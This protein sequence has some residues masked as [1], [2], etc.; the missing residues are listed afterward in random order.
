MTFRFFD[1]SE[2]KE[3]LK[4]VKKNHNMVDELKQETDDV[5]ITKYQEGVT[6]DVSP[7]LPEECG[8]VVETEW[9]DKPYLVGEVKNK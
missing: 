7:V 5:E 1:N 2:R 4:R 6:E 3:V 8:I 9:V